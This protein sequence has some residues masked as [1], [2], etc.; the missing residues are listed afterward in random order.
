MYDMTAA[1]KIL[2]L[3]TYVSVRNL[4]NN[5]EIKVR[6]NDRGPFVKERIIDL[7]YTAAREL[8]IAGPGT[9]EVE[10]IALGL[11]VDE[12]GWTRSYVPR[13]YYTGNFTIQIGAFSVFGNAQKL[14]ND[15]DDT[16]KNVHISEFDDGK[17]L[18]YRVRVGKCT[19]LE[20][21][22]RYESI[23]VQRG[24]EGAFVIAE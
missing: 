23:L 19:T 2:P 5:R 16:Y 17:E 15:L 10:V 12:N 4:E 14:K 7:S 18:Y 22:K 13:D 6:I 11:P 3:G 9:S 1:H 21:A 20:E 8:G 24:F